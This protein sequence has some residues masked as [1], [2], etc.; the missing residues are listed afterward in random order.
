MARDEFV[1][2]RMYGCSMQGWKRALNTPNEVKARNSAHVAHQLTQAQI[3]QAFQ[4][5]RANLL[6]AFFVILLLL[7][8]LFPLL[9][10]ICL[11]GD[12]QGPL[13]RKFK[14]SLFWLTL[15]FLNQSGIADL[16]HHLSSFKLAE[17]VRS[18]HHSKRN[19]GELYFIKRFVYLTILEI[20]SPNSKV[21]PLGVHHQSRWHPGDSTWERERAHGETGR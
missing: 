8:T 4:D 21:L 16:F 3:C 6:E 15:S 1:V 10:C 18:M 2:S 13:L 20:E 19:P 14:E 7:S 9:N 5:C 11:L 17:C 12:L